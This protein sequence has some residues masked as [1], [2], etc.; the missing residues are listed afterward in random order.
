[1]ATN[2]VYNWWVLT[3]K[4]GMMCILIMVVGCHD[5]KL[6]IQLIND[7]LRPVVVFFCLCLLDLLIPDCVVICVFLIIHQFLLHIICC[8]TDTSIKDC[9][10]FIEK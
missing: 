4:L 8:P 6:S 3:G 1:M 10:M 7:V 5:Q 9:Y 2:V